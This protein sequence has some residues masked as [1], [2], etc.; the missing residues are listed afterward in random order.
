MKRAFAF[1]TRIPW[2]WFFIGIGLLLLVVLAVAAFL[3]A[4]F[5]PNSHKT[6]L[7]AIVKDKTGRELSIPGEMRLKLLPT[8]RLE[9]DR[10]I[11][12]EKDST[13]AFATIEAVKLSLR[14]WPL[15]RSKVILDQVEIGN[16]NVALKRF[17]NGT[18]NFDDLMPKDDQPS[19]L[20][21]DLAGLTINNG[22][23]RFDD[24]LAQRKTQISNLKVTAGRLTDNVATP[25]RAR[26]L[27][28]NDHPVATLQTDL[29]AELKFDLQRK[30][31]L[32]NALK[33]LAQGEAAN[34]KPV[35]IGLTANID[36]D[37][38]A[39]SIAVQA[40]KATLDG[41]SGAQT[42]HG[43]FALPRLMSR[44]SEAS[45]EQI[46]VSLSVVDPIKKIT[47]NVIMPALASMNSKVDAPS[48]KL[49]FTFDKD[50]VH[51]IGELS[52][53]LAL[54]VAQ[55]RAAL[56]SLTITSTTRINRLTVQASAKG[57]ISLDL[58]SGDLDA[59]QLNGDWRIQSEADQLAGKWHAP[60]LANIVN[61][62]FSVDGLRGDW[63]GKL[64]GAVVSGNAAV[65]V[66][67][68]WRE[69][70]AKIPTIDLNTVLAWPDSGLEANIR[71]LALGHADLE[72][73][74]GADQ[75]AAKGVSLKATGHNANGKWQ[76]NLAS[77]VN[78]DLTKQLA[79]FTHLAGRVSWIG[80]S[81][82][83]KPFE[84]K[85]NGGGTVDLAREQAQFK[86]RAGLDQSKFDGA[87]AV[88]GWADPAYRIDAS[89][90][91]LDLDRY[92]PVAANRD[93]TKSKQKKTAP[94]NL[95]LSFLKPLKVDGQIKIGVLKSAGT[96]ARN[97]RIELESLPAKKAK[98]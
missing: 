1:P 84:L 29:N 57:P 7:A 63:S 71:V 55:R 21:F 37:L 25:I 24:E 93:A 30:H 94:A 74:S 77:P 41:R 68:N 59:T 44:P 61:G 33:I 88:T 95:D 64:A 17:A 42:L 75:I 20:H 92:F 79:E 10:A 35:S 2:R 40:A 36:A 69:Y 12:N 23:L 22:A 3:I 82:A 83:A 16:F 48:F 13:Q 73:W 78:M 51:S 26:F 60:L 46:K 9:L 98:P 91:Q 47:F 28:T 31:Y 45:L 72:A 58:Q 87:F 70:S 15:L 54:D 86:L 80:F 43:E 62:N 52:G 56:S 6:R 11:L 27:L 32:V 81:K 4:T 53:V 90:D 76:A 8:L 39:G 89:L 14:P 67:G 38:D 96:T 85:L 65:P 19:T 18:T 66:H 97:V 50:N 34:V 49:N 5:D